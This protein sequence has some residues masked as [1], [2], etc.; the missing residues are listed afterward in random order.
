MNLLQRLTQ[1]MLKQASERH[2]FW[3]DLVSGSSLYDELRAAAVMQKALDWENVLDSAVKLYRKID[4]VNYWKTDAAEV[5]NLA[6]KKR[7]R[8]QL[9]H[10]TKLTETTTSP[11]SWENLG[12]EQEVLTDRLKRNSQILV[13]LIWCAWKAWQVNFKKDSGLDELLK[14]ADGQIQ[15]GIAFDQEVKPGLINKS[16]SLVLQQADRDC[17]WGWIRSFKE[18]SQP[19]MM[20]RSATSVDFVGAHAN[21]EELVMS[22]RLEIL[23][24]GTGFAFLHPIDAFKIHCDDSFTKAVTLALK[25][26]CKGLEKTACGRFRVFQGGKS[27]PQTLSGNSAGAAAFR[28][29][30]HALQGCVPDDGVVVLAALKEG[31]N[32]EVVGLDNVDGLEHKVPAISRLAKHDTIFVANEDQV[33]RVQKLLNSNTMIRVSTAEGAT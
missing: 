27:V 22:L 26:A 20:I 6:V 10:L 1:L 24:G 16:P 12:A 14:T 33:S 4:Q 18:Q 13:A 5:Y 9:A 19:H 21:Y 11:A 32:G 15:F 8:N 23:E 31:V 3:L 2:R 17:L 29:W 25:T 30:Y 7:D 28:G